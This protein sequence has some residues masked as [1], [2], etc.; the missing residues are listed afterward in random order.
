MR[1]LTELEGDRNRLQA[2][3][4]ALEELI[5]P[6]KQEEGRLK[7]E[8]DHADAILAHIEDALCYFT[9]VSALEEALELAKVEAQEAV[10]VAWANLTEWQAT[11]STNA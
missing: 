1:K 5:R 4:V 2:E 7:M 10:C 3:V 9:P 11:H 8:V 6:F